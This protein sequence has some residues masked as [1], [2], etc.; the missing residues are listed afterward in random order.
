VLVSSSSLSPSL[1]EDSVSSLPLPV[2]LSLVG[3]L[4]L[5][6]EQPAI[7]AADPLTAVVRK[8]RLVELFSFA[9]IPP[10]QLLAS[11]DCLI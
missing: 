7:A 8:R 5:L 3:V 11:M 4:L 9:S 1:V 10:P 2:L 6:L